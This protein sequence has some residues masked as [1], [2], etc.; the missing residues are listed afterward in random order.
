[1]HDTL[2]WTVEAFP[3]VL[4]EIERRNAAFVARGQ[5]PYL[6]VGLD[7]FYERWDGGAAARRRRRAR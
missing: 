4:D 3:R 6:I 2:P 5:E 1:M 7:A